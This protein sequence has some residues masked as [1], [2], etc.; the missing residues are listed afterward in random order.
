[1]K[2]DNMLRFDRFGVQECRLLG[3]SL[4]M[5]L[6]FGAPRAAKR[7]NSRTATPFLLIFERAQN[8]HIFEEVER[9]IT[10]SFFRIQEGHTGHWP[11]YF[12]RQEPLGSLLNS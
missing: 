12:G 8:M 5:F 2:I 1:M 11:E 10:K 3:P 7:R 9:S 4:D 6:R